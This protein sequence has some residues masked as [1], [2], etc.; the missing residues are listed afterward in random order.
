MTN[1]K[2]LEATTKT[3]T[4]ILIKNFIFVFITIFIFSCGKSNPQQEKTLARVGDKKLYAKDLIGLVGI[5][6]NK[7]DS[8]EIINRYMQT[9]IRKQLL[10]QQAQKDTKI[11]ENEIERKL[12]DYRYDLL[13]YEFEKDYVKKNLDTN[14]KQTEIDDYYKNNPANFELKQNIIKAFLI[15]TTKNEEKKDEI[16]TTISQGD[17]QKIKE[18]CAKSSFQAILNDSTWV[19]FEQMIKNTPFQQIANKTDFL[20]ANRFSESSDDVSTY[21]LLIKDYKISNQPSPLEFVRNRIKQ[22]IVNQR[23]VQLLQKMEKQ[24]YEDAKKNKTFE[25]FK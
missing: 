17:N 6:T 21:Y 13:A 12:L 16:R 7:K 25:I 3:F 23:K 2:H 15:K 24:M 22:M 20:R 9:W 11:N 8:I 14:V 18:L 1:N 5:G 10:L 4:K 19:E